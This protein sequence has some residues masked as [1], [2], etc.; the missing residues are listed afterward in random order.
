MKRK[1]VV[2]TDWYSKTMLTVITVALSL[3][4][5]RIAGV[6]WGRG[7]RAAT[8][9]KLGHVWRPEPVDVN[10]KNT[11][12]IPVEVENEPLEVTVSR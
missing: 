11:W 10:V 12:A 5:L 9:V 3:I 6:D 1:R 7:V 4:C 8:G 2:R